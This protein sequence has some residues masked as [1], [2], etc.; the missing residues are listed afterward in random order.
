MW[1][2]IYKITLRAVLAVITLTEAMF[3]SSLALPPL[4]QG[5]KGVGTL[6]YP[7]L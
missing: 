5:G 6:Q 7:S 4:S 2:T 1:Q 3:K